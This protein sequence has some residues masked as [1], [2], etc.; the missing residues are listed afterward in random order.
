MRAL[1][2]AILDAIRAIA[3]CEH[4]HYTQDSELEFSVCD[5]CGAM[6]TYDGNGW[7]FPTLVAAAIKA[8]KIK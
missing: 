6:G 7:S 2:Y 5:D 3:E 8:A 4:D 1:Q